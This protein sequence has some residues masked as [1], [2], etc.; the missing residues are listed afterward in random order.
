MTLL[1]ASIWISKWPLTASKGLQLPPINLN[2]LP[3]KF[4]CSKDSFDTPHANVSKHRCQ[5]LNFGLHFW[6]K[7]GLQWPLILDYI[8]QVVV[9]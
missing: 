6:P 8:T 1:V 3:I 5:T 7:N 2:L 9:K 4:I